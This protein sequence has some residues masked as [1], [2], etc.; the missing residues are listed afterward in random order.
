MEVHRDVI[1][2]YPDQ[3][4][5]PN[6]TL[7]TILYIRE[8]ADCRPGYVNL[9]FGHLGQYFD[10]ALHHSLVR[11]GNS[12][13]V[14]SDLY[15]EVHVNLRSKLSGLQHESNGPSST[16]RISLD[17]DIVQCFSCKSW[18]K[19]ADEWITR[20]RLY[21]W[22]CQTL[23]EKIVRS[24]C[25]LVPVG[26]KCSKS[27]FLQWRISLV[28]AERSLVHS[29]SHI[30]LQVY[31]LLKYFLKQIQATLKEAIGDDDILCS[32]FLKTVLFHAIE[33]T[34]QKLW[35][36]KYLFYCFWFCFNILIAWIRAGFCP[37]Y[38]IP[39]NNLFKRKVHG[40]SQ[41]ILL[42]ILTNYSTLKWMCLSVGTF[43]E[44]SIWDDLCNITMQAV[45]AK[46]RLVPEIILGQDLTT[47]YYMPVEKEICGFTPRTITQAF[48]SLTTLQSED[49]QVYAYRY[50]TK[51]LDSLAK[52]QLDADHLLARENKSRYQ[53]LRKCKH[54]MIPRSSMGTDL[55]YLATFHFLTGNYRKSRDMSQQ[56]MKLASYYRVNIG[57]VHQ[58][59]IALYL[60]EFH[61]PGNTVD[62]L[63]RTC[64]DVLFFYHKTMHLPHLCL[65]LLKEHRNIAIPPLP[66]ALFLSFLCCH[67]LR[68]TRGRDTALHNL[69]KVQEHEAQG[70]HK[71]WI[72][73]TLLGICYQILG[74]FQKAIR[75]Y[76][77]S[78]QSKTHYHEWNPAIERI[79]VVHLC[80]YASHMSNR[81]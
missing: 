20:T 71:F 59:M 81:E 63:K 5:S 75:A 29:F 43:F 15:R 44:S 2:M 12:M 53:R 56:V 38:F 30:Q 26:D 69:I 14:S 34:S 51:G 28:T 73:H 49:D 9:E 25:H 39:T 54:W 32:Y 80:I 46:P 74:D 24:G 52:E 6:D 10:E 57:E 64:T 33:N 21:G 47:L 8:A 1:V 55:L 4:I 36:E 45:L 67:E 61:H 42:D 77:K 40:Q 31:A 68:D 62:R 22:P 41:K 66:Y 78:A 48:N 35:Q 37:N 23:I 7:K 50:A 3:C 18:P 19:E 13:F 11:R 70:G 76:W 79:A 58:D 65:E 17:Y 72:V 60:R 27:T 16:M